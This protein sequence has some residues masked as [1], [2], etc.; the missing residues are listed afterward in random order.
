MLIRTEVSGLDLAL[1]ENSLA[2]LHFGE[3]VIPPIRLSADEAERVTM[4]MTKAQ[5]WEWNQ[6][7]ML[8]QRAV[9]RYRR[10]LAAWLTMC[11]AAFAAYVSYPDYI[12]C[13]VLALLSL[14]LWWRAGLAERR[15]EEE[16]RQQRKDF[17][18]DWD[19]FRERLEG[20]EATP[21][22]SGN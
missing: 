13:L 5:L 1:E 7:E 6:L 16:A 11:V 4:E 9:M 19:Y 3:Q 14:L 20:A 21:P 17:R 18:A 15:A 2:L 8:R 12:L 10:Y 22:P